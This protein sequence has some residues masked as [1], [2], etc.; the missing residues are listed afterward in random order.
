[1]AVSLIP[2]TAAVSG[3]LPLAN[4]GTATTGA[5]A[6]AAYPSVAANLSNSTWTKIALNTKLYDTNNNFNTSTYRFT[7]PVAG[8][9]NLS[10]HLTWYA[11]NTA[12]TSDLGMGFFKNGSSYVL[13]EYQ[14]SNVLNGISDF[15]VAS[16]TV[17]MD[18]AANDYVEIKINPFGSSYGSGNFYFGSGLRTNFSGYLVG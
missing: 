9:Y 8:K 4:G 6:F 3:T 2:L 1:M 17:L 16:A 15:T 11:D 5:P 13:G 10:Y 18:L 12:Y 14:I 7:A